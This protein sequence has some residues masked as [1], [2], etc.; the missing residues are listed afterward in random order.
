MRSKTKNKLKKNVENI[1]ERVKPSFGGA[2]GQSNARGAV[3]GGFFCIFP[4]RK[5]IKKKKQ[6]I[7]FTTPMGG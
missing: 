3:A 5:N 1:K 6:K 7:F 4:R 2:G